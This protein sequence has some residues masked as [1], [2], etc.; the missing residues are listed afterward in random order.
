MTD[1]ITLDN[2]SK[3]FGSNKILDGFNLS[4]K[5]GDLVAFLGPSGCGKTTALRCIAGLTALDSGRITVGG[6]DITDAPPNKRNTTMVFQSYALFPH[7]SVEENINFGLKMHGIP[8]FRAKE[9]VNRIIET[10]RLQGLTGRYPRQLSGGQQQ[11]VALARALVMNPDILLLDEPL[12]NLDAK[13]RHEM[14]VEIRMLHESLGLTTIFVTHDQDEAL[15]LADRIV[16]INGGQIIQNDSP[17]KVFEQPKSYF[18]ADFTSVRNFFNGCFNG[19]GNS[20]ITDRGLHITCADRDTGKKLVGV[21]PNRIIVNPSNPK[22]YQNVHQA[23]ICFATYRGNIIEMFTDLGGKEV[24]VEVPA[25]NY[26]GGNLERGSEVTLAW[27]DRD[28]LLLEHS[29]GN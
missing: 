29:T 26:D 21:R 3:S 12:S 28:S 11:R 2:L 17:R 22:D 27:R 23:T 15:T 19:S 13:L 8:K 5:K 16:V 25:A 6:K 4:V 20:F 7:M 9:K 10:T 18:V 14:R 24:I 1:Y